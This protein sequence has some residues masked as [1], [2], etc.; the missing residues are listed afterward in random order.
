MEVLFFILSYI[1]FLVLAV[2]ALSRLIKKGILK[3]GLFV[4]SFLILAMFTFLLYLNIQEE[5]VD[6]DF[7]SKINSFKEVY[8][9]SQ[10][11]SQIVSNDSNL[12]FIVH[13]NDITRGFESYKEAVIYA[14]EIQSNVYFL[15]D[16]H[17]VWRYDFQ[18]PLSILLDAPLISQ[19]PELPRGCEVTSLAMFLNYA[20]VNVN[21][22][23]LAD[24][25]KKDSTP[26]QKKGDQVFFGNPYDGF[27]GDMYNINNPGYGVYHGPIKELAEFYLPNRVIDITGTDFQHILYHVSNGNPVWIISNV[28]FS[29]LPENLFETWDT[30]S[31]S[32]KITYKEHSV[33]VTGFDD[34]YVYFNDPLA[35]VKNRKIPQRDFVEAWEQMGKQA[36][37]FVN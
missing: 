31:G 37:T 27:V 14:Q 18:L 35:N 28:T 12:P 10:P 6:L 13:E 23:V 2:T 21:K 5:W 33:L 3:Q 16:S 11:P 17:I 36:I 20:G 8:S 30:P 7:T 15:N 32:V 24:E 34:D 4:F 19:L 9:N 26:Y 29:K 25:V 22:M 1:V